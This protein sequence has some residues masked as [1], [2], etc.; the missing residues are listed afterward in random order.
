M[1]KVLLIDGPMRGQVI[2]RRDAAPIAFE[3][4]GPLAADV[5]LRIGYYH[6]HR[7]WLFGRV[8]R[9]GTV[10]PGAEPPAEPMIAPFWEFL[11]APLAA[12]L[13]EPQE[14]WMAWE[15]RPPET[16]P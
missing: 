15:S 12:E 3:N 8:L 14:D 13:A 1:A 6:V 11:A 2:E 7:Y 4:P 10:F 5:T 9:V 16:R